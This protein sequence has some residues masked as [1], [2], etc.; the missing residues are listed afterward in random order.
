MS[1]E[2]Q[3]FEKYLEKIEDPKNHEG[4]NYDLP[5]N[6]TPL[7][8][9]KFKLCKRMLTYQLETNLTDQEIAKKI[10]LSVAETQDILFCC[11]EKFTLD[12]LLTYASQLLSPAE[13]NI[14]VEI[15]R[16]STHARTV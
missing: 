2:E 13:I 3:E 11:I 5:E 16:T 9:T 14:S 15:K 10:N 6:P 4:V 8:L 1:E 12:R 7:Q